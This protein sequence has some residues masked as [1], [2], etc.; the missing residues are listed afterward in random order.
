MNDHELT[1]MVER[2]ASGACNS[3]LAI[4]GGL[5][6]DELDAATKNN[7]REAALPFIYQGVKALAELG[8]VKLADQQLAAWDEGYLACLLQ[9]QVGKPARNPYLTTKDA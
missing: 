3:R 5:P 7:Y 6:W 4:H 2:A 9:A 1:V 8:Y